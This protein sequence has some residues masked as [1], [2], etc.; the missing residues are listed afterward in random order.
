VNH[1]YSQKISD[2][3]EYTRQINR[4]LKVLSSPSPDFI[5]GYVRNNSY[6]GVK[7][8]PFLFD[9]FKPLMIRIKEIDDYV[10][11]DANLD[12]KTNSIQFLDR[13]AVSTKFGT[14][15]KTDS[16]EDNRFIWVQFLYNHHEQNLIQM[17]KLISLFIIL[18]ALTSCKKEEYIKHDSQIFLNDNSQIIG[19]WKYLFTV[20]GGGYIG[21]QIKSVQDIPN[22]KINPNGDYEKFKD[23]HVLSKGVI[24]TIKT[25]PNGVYVKFYPNG[26]KTHIDVSPSLSVL[27]SDT[28][29]ITTASGDTFKSEHYKRN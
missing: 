3:N 7:G 25:F 11:V 1:T 9:E 23:S 8:R 19:T 18:I 27:N 20:S 16:N 26:I 21:I 22:L 13:A 5:G 28:L 14:S 24:D 10:S 15:D 29:L 2:P 6:E 4:K 12:L 17:K